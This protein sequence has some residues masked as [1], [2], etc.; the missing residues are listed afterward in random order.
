MITAMMLFF[1]NIFLAQPGTD[2]LVA[3]SILSATLLSATLVPTAVS[4]YITLLGSRWIGD[5]RFA[6][7]WGLKLA[8]MA[9][10]TVWLLV[11][12]VPFYLNFRDSNET[13]LTNDENRA[14]VDCLAEG[15]LVNFFA[16]L[17]I[18]IQSYEI[19][20][21]ALFNAFNNFKSLMYANLL[22]FFIGYLPVALLATY[23]N[24]D[25]ASGTVG[26]SCTFGSTV[27]NGTAASSAA[28]QQN[29]GS[30]DI[31]FGANY[32]MF[33]A[34]KLGSLLYMYITS[35]RPQV[36]EE[37]A[38][39]FRKLHF[40]DKPETEFLDLDAQLGVWCA[41]CKGRGCG[42]MQSRD[43]GEEASLMKSAPSTTYSEA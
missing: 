11:F 20:Y 21:I 36:L 15:T 1:T 30:W 8:A 24:T 13:S 38:E 28:D 14:T 35:I 7:F 37:Q 6:D 10:T 9:V 42:C 39:L 43:D 41:C 27:V 31:V 2:P 40:D 25:Y 22:G 19:I 34:V 17:C 26:D 23:V 33:H 32:P 4:A 16:I 29:A 18:F 3:Y 12:A 5:S